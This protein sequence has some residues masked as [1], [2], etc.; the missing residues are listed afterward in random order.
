MRIED[1]KAT[2]WKRTFFVVLVMGIIIVGLLQSNVNAQKSPIE[3]TSLYGFCQNLDRGNPIWIKNGDIITYGL[4]TS[5]IDAKWM[6][7]RN[8]YL[9][10]NSGSNYKQEQINIW[11][12]EDWNRFVNSGH[13]YACP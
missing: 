12:K 3:N 7:E 9:V 8:I 2:F 11:G 6:L 5:Y 13:T 4:A 1:Q 10:Y